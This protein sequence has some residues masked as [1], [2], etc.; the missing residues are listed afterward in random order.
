MQTYGSGILCPLQEYEDNIYSKL[1]CLF[2]K[3]LGLSWLVSS[4]QEDFLKSCCDLSA[5]SSDAILDLRSGIENQ[6]NSYRK[7]EMDLLAK[8]FENIYRTLT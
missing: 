7:N 6:I 5:L 1:A 8:S 3:V 2:P 4:N